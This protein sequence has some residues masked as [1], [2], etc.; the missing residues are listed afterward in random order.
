MLEH[1]D[2]E[3]R[4]RFSDGTVDASGP[5]LAALARDHDVS[6]GAIRTAVAGPLPEHTAEGQEE[7][8]ALELP[9]TLDIPGKVADFLRATELEPDERA[10]RDQGVTV[11]RGRGGTP[12]VSDVPAVHRGLLAGCR[13]LD[14][15]QDLPAVPTQREA[16][17]DH[18]NRV[19]A[20]TP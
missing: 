5:L 16:R 7:V 3:L 9:V 11:R 8:P 17:P 12:R 13:P 1:H 19:S 10:P 4:A 20:L 14:G 18:E 15:R 6:R 2:D